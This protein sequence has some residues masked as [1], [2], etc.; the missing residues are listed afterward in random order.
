MSAHYNKSYNIIS[1]HQTHTHLTKYG[2]LT[3]EKIA[4]LW[5]IIHLLWPLLWTE[6][7]N[8]KAKWF[9][10]VCDFNSRRWTQMLMFHSKANVVVK[11]ISLSSLLKLTWM[12][13]ELRFEHSILS[14]TQWPIYK[15]WSLWSWMNRAFN[16]E[17]IVLC[18]E[19]FQRCLYKTHSKSAWL[20]STLSRVMQA[21]LLLLV[22]IEKTTLNI[23]I[24]SRMYWVTWHFNITEWFILMSD[25]EINRREGLLAGWITS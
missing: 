22:S 7:S 8:H 21:D 25:G 1:Q 17:I 12:N 19:K 2:K 20:L 23:N 9:E 14:E 18:I 24:P 3:A 6:L 15:V 5:C 4:L 13:S 11:N 16:I 10:V